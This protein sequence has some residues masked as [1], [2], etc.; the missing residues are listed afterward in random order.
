MQY[1]SSKMRS[2]KEKFAKAAAK[3]E[4]GEKEKH[5]LSERMTRNQVWRDISRRAG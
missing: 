4:K 3:G 5:E 2:L 1:Y